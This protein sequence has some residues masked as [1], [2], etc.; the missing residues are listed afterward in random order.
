MA[1]RPIGPGP[2]P[3]TTASVEDGAAGAG[4][5]GAPASRELVR[6]AV[7]SLGHRRPLALVAAGVAVAA[8]AVMIPLALTAGGGDPGAAMLDAVNLAIAHHTADI[9][10]EG[11]IHTKGTSSEMTGSGQVDFADNASSVEVDITGEHLEL[12]ALELTVTGTVYEQI[13][14]LSRIIPGKTWVSYGGSSA[15]CAPA[16]GTMGLLGA[17]ADPVAA[18]RLLQHAAGTVTALGTGTLDGNVVQGYEV[19]LDGAEI[20]SQVSRVKDPGFLRDVQA[21]LGLTGIDYRLY[22]TGTGALTSMIVGMHGDAAGHRFSATVSALYSAY[23]S[24]MHLS[25]PPASKVIGLHQFLEDGG[26]PSQA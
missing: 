1:D 15:L 17:V 13:P 7:R 24:A 25:A 21:L 18:L 22:V 11:A 16:V 23:G 20:Q 6:R 14:D 3:P 10:I 4:A 19:T 26:K 12:S 5:A 9:T 8:A 2:T